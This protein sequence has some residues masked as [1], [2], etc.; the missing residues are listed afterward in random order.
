MTNYKLSNKKVKE[1]N[2]KLVLM[3]VLQHGP[4]SRIEISKKTHL[5]RSTVSE[6]VNDLINKGLIKENKKAFDKTGPGKKPILLIPETNKFYVIGY[7]LSI[8]NSEIIVMDLKGSIIL[9]EPFISLK[10][11]ISIKNLNEIINLFKE[12][13]KSI[14][15]SL[16]I[17]EESI[18]GMGI[19]FPGLVSPKN[20]SLSLTPNLEQ[21][22]DF[23]Q[24]R[25]FSKNLGI[26]IV[27]DN[28]ANMKAL[29]ELIYGIGKKV[30]DFLLVNVSYGIGSGLV[31]EGKLFRGKYNLSGEIGHLK[32]TEDGE[33]CTCGKKGCLETFSSV[34]SIVKKYYKMKGEENDENYEINKII[35]KAQNGDEIASKILK[36]SGF[37]LGK[38]I[39]NILNILN[40]QSVVL[41][42]EIIKYWELVKKDFYIGLNETTLNLIS[43]NID[44][45]LS[46]LGEE[47]TAVG[48]ASMVLEN[49]MYDNF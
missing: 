10:K 28:N 5:T 1:N 11:L 49:I 3:E 16:N 23:S 33:T 43:T 2:L 46:E 38:A 24:I 29:G 8:T 41:T 18:R 30:N 22:F 14:V 32:I 7:D 9:K 19:A 15:S 42:G 31:L 20:N 12:N 40:L 26:P 45:S 34:R 4:I 37:Y 35:K 13:F 21:Y 36:T 44:I 6:L 25:M 17:P 27:V 39:G 47:I 48:A